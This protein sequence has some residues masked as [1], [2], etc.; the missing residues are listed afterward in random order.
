VTDA[1]GNICLNTTS[2]TFYQNS[3]GKIKGGE[4]EV[5]FRPI[6]ALMI[7][8]SYGYTDFT[9]DDLN[10]PNIVIDRPAY[11]PKQNWTV[12][13]SYAFGF[14]GGSTLTP[15]MDLYSQ[16]QICTG[17]TSLRSC[18]DG[19]QLLNA[20]LEWGSPERTWTAAVG[21]N[22]LTNEDYFYNKFDLAAFGQPTTEGQPG[23]PRE[24]YVTFT[25]NF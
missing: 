25:R 3:P 23:A 12:G 9:A 13:A 19:Y 21:A 11:V 1:L 24:W 2:R 10:A 17:V 15:R 4:L 18:S 20:R 7:T 5:A 14:S 16:S 6:D 22:N 8:G